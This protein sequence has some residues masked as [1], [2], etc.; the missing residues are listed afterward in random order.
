MAISAAVRTGARW[1]VQLLALVAKMSL[2][3]WDRLLEAKMS[4]RLWDRLLEAKMSLRL[5]DRLLEAKMSLRLWARLLEAI[6]R[7]QSPMSVS[8][9]VRV[10]GSWGR[11]C[12]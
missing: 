12:H 5:W 4:L 11:R 7:S 3:L 6:G 9:A 1:V 8:R 10:V 2:R